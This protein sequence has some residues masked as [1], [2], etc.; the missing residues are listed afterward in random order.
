MKFDSL[1]LP[2]SLLFRVALRRR[3][4]CSPTRPRAEKR[5]QLL[6]GA[7]WRGT[8][9]Q[10]AARRYRADRY[11]GG[12]E[13]P[14]EQQLHDEPAKGVPDQYRRFGLTL[15]NGLVAFDDFRDTH[16]GQPRVG[17]CQLIANRTVLERPGG[18]RRVIAPIR[19]VRNEIP[20]AERR[21]PCAVDKN[22]C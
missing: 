19:K 6:C 5:P 22:D 8:Q 7:P 21:Y 2:Q 18:R 10:H 13:A 9:C 20:P 4:N 3:K 16:L 12:S 15:D 14:I 1:S 17:T 11:A